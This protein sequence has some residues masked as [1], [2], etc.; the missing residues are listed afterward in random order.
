MIGVAG[1]AQL[2][3]LEAI[4]QDAVIERAT[5]EAAAATYFVDYRHHLATEESVVLPRAASVLT[6]QD[7]AAVA[8]AVPTAA[9]PHFGDDI[10]ARFR[11]LRKQIMLET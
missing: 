6:P 2:D 8:S 9:D 11:E 1:K 3:H 10:G 7:W 4:L 5:V